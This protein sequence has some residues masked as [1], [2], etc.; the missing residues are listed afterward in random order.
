MINAN[1]LQQPWLHDLRVTVDGP[2]T[3]VCDDGGDVAGA[4]TGVFVDDRRVVSQLVL[5]LDGQAP[6]PVASV[7]IGATSEH[8]LAARHLGD[9]G[10][11]PTVQIHRRRRLE[12]ASFE[13]TVVVISNA[14][15]PVDAMLHLDVAGDGVEI[16]LVKRGG[17]GPPLAVTTGPLG[18]RDERHATTLSVDP[19]P[20]INLQPG[21]GVRL[22]WPIKLA[23]GGSTSVTLRGDVRRTTATA[24]DADAGS[25]AADWDPDELAARAPDRRLADVVRVSMI[26]LRHLLLRDPE[27]ASDLVA[28]AG[29]PWYLTMFGRDALWSARFMARISPALAAGTLRA[30]ARRQATAMDAETAA[31]PGK[32]L[33]EVRRTASASAGNGLPPLYYGTVDATPLWIILLEEAATTG[34]PAEEVAALGP[35]LSGA[36]DWMADAVGRSSAGFLQYVDESGHGLSNQGWKDS[37]DAMRRADG[38]IAPAPI[39]LLEAQA[40]AFAAARAA[41]RLLRTFVPSATVGH[42]P[43]GWDRWADA[44]SDRVRERFWVGGDDPYLAMALDGTGR[45]VD[46]VGSNMG[47]VLGTG[48]INPDESNR[49]VDR[50][51]RPDLLRRF[52]IGTLSAENPAYN[53]IGYHTG[54][55]WVHDTA[56]SMVGMAAVGRVDDARVLG[57]RLVDLGAALDGRLPELCGGETVAGRPV[58]YPAAC[59]PQ[60]WSA[61]SAAVLLDVL[62]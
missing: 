26:D 62:G 36:L 42:D 51:M 15:G 9:A 24:F 1:R 23:S 53:P 3:V 18:W 25:S 34:M 38:S 46:A 57:E 2:S 45:P 58:P 33:H 11:D 43:D 41:A 39:A 6:T 40:Y 10:A 5:S 61:A 50:L 31:E 48:L 4:G 60:A 30:L 59:R 52:G 56:I 17:T 49:V 21:G 22:T 44:L 54:S 20:A 37:G 32:I 12:G 29:S 19:D 16:A 35:N 28:A 14:I 13:E 8:W 55:V 7:A 27:R 47:H